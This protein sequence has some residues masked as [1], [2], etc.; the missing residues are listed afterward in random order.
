VTLDEHFL[1][2]LE[3]TPHSRHAVHLAHWRP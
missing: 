1:R 3:K 2:K